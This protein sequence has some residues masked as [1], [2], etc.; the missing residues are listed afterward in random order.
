MAVNARMQPVRPENGHLNS[1]LQNEP[2]K[3]DREN[4]SMRGCP[5][6]EFYLQMI[7]KPTEPALLER[8]LPDLQV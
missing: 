5:D 2:T 6:G 1:E 4:S 3:L 8:D 7:C